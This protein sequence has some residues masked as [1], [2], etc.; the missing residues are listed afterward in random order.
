MIAPDL[1]GH[2]D[3]ATPRGD[4]S[5]G[6]HAA[7][8]R[9]LL[10]A[11]GVDGRRSSATRSAAAWRCSSSSSSPSAPSG[12]C[13][14]R[15]AAS[16]GRSARC[17][18]A[19]RCRARR[20]CLLAG[21]DRVSCGLDRRRRRAARR[22]TGLGVYLQAIA[23][24]L[25]P[26]ERPGRAR[27]VPADAARGDRRAR[28]AGQRARPALPARGM[29]TLIVW[30][31]RDH[32]IPVEHGRARTRRARTA[33]SRRCRGGAFPAP[34]GPEGLAAACS[35]SSPRPSRPDRRRV[36]GRDPAPRAPPRPRA[37]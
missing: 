27:G 29:P 34:R 33:A 19:P 13:W 16:A 24:A 18:A 26:L 11:L 37:A 3:S 22:G 14:C 20:R 25:R 9:D 10:A 30:G 31:G 5:L 32:T 8:I 12:W 17:C 36:L 6:A 23:R 35:T 15:A 7:V 4:Y 2:G 28:P 1:I 21:A